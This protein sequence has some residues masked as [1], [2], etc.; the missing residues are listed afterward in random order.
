MS[1]M[2][3]NST[4]D[5]SFFAHLRNPFPAPA[6]ASAQVPVTGAQPADNDSSS[7]SAAAATATATTTVTC[8]VVSLDLSPSIPAA[9]LPD[10]FSVVASNFV[11]ARHVSQ[12]HPALC[13]LVDCVRGH[14]SNSRRVYLVQEAHPKTLSSLLLSLSG[15]G[16]G[17][18]GGNGS[19]SGVRDHGRLLRW[20]HTILSGLAFLHAHG[21]QHR[22]LHLHN[23][24]HISASSAGADKSSSSDSDPYDGDKDADDQVKLFNFATYYVTNNG[25]FVASPV[26][27]FTVQPPEVLLLPSSLDSLSFPSFKADTWAF[28]LLLWHL[29]FGSPLL[30]TADPRLVFATLADFCKQPQTA[31][32]TYIAQRLQRINLTRP[33]LAVDIENDPIVQL[34][35]AALVVDPKLRPMPC[36]LLL[37]H[38]VFHQNSPRPLTATMG[39]TDQRTNLRVLFHLWLST[40]GNLDS[41]YMRA[42]GA[43]SRPAL[44]ELPFELRIGTSASSSSSLLTKISGSHLAGHDR[45][46]FPLNFKPILES[47]WHL[48][49][50]VAYSS[51][52]TSSTDTQSQFQRIQLLTSLLLTYPLSLP[53]LQS[54]LHALPANSLPPLLRSDIWLALLNVTGPVSLM[55]AAHDHPPATS[56]PADDVLT[57]QLDAD[58]QRCHTY[59]P[60][61]SSPAGQVHLQRLIRAWL[62]AHPD[63]VYW[64]G[65]DSVCA[66]FASLFPGDHLLPYAFA[67]LEGFVA[68]YLEAYLGADNQAALNAYFARLKALVMYLDPELGAHMLDA[69]GL[70]FDLFAV[71]W[72]L[73]ACAH[74]L[75]L[76]LVYLVWD[77]LLVH[78]HDQHAFLLHVLVACLR[79]PTVRPGIMQARAFD[80]AVHRIVDVSLRE[81]ASGLEGAKRESKAMPRSVHLGLMRDGEVGADVVMRISLADVVEVGDNVRVIDVRFESAPPQG[82]QHI[83]SS[84][85]VPPAN[86]HAIENILKQ[87]RL[88]K[89]ITV[90]RSLD[91]A[92]AS[93]ACARLIS[94]GIAG[95]CWLEEDGKVDGEVVA[96][97]K[98]K[99]CTCTPTAISLPAAGGG[100]G[101]VTV[102]KCTH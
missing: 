55:F 92:E 56:T 38:P 8:A 100:G 12:S 79:A 37:N 54:T 78:Q 34:I 61:L 96:R 74:V 72:G 10:T 4:H 32:K 2:H 101:H 65:F 16:A 46:P 9:N 102:Y 28:G 1:T 80:E 49:P 50:T 7:A 33:H 13:Q 35:S 93:K 94:W 41:E 25:Q 63:K 98:D 71:P 20:S 5:F 69:I 51:P 11:T 42:T 29:Y 62:H 66:V 30:P 26:T 6:P 36:D 21:I 97:D 57:R 24:F 17:G 45:F 19:G 52:A 14:V 89:R 27:S 23:I 99:V 43:A 76:P 47:I 53:T 84:T 58:T 73:T 86:L 88:N 90:V 22:N 48:T 75:P 95:V 44:L 39:S 18:G 91:A 40:G 67:A 59:H 81:V 82:S 3:S 87:Q 60:H 64:Q 15:P 77:H 70:T 31:I 85:F 83:K 68:R